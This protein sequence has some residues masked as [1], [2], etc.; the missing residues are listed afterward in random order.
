MITKDEFEQFKRFYAYVR[1]LVIQKMKEMHTAR[2]G[3]PFYDSETIDSVEYIPE[4]D[5]FIVITTEYYSC[6]SDTNYH[7]VPPYFLY[8]EN[9]MQIYLTELEQQRLSEERRKQA[10]KEQELIESDKKERATLE[11]LAKKY[12]YT[13]HPVSNTE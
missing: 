6:G 3:K 7:S 12:N 11:R 8:D 9:A 10:Q 13:I 4:D 1:P 5:Q 2:T